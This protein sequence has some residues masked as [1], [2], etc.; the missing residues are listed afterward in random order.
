[1]VGGCRSGGVR[2]QADERHRAKNAWQGQS[3]QEAA[4]GEGLETRAD[5]PGGQ[6]VTHPRIPHESRR[7]AGFCQFLDEKLTAWEPTI[8]SG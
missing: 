8:V 3:V 4:G 1:M 2:L 7:G 6:D 5:I